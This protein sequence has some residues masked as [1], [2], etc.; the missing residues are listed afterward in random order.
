MCA[1]RASFS[2]FCSVTSFTGSIFLASTTIFWPPQLDEHGRLELEVAWFRRCPV[3]HGRGCFRR[4]GMVGLLRWVVHA[5]TQAIAEREP[6]AIG[7]RAYPPVP[8]I[9][10]EEAEHQREPM[11]QPSRRDWSSIDTRRASMIA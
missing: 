1:S 4:S 9:V 2:R 6:A 11:R 10:G 8:G 5:D 3:A 7:P